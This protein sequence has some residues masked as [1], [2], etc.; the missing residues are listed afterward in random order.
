MTATIL[1][2]FLFAMVASGT[3]ICHD[4]VRLSAGDGVIRKRRFYR[5][6][7]AGLMAGLILALIFTA[8][9]LYW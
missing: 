9:W 4:I 1:V 5:I 3:V 8:W 7:F 6:T 2:I